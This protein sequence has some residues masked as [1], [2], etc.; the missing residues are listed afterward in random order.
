MRKKIVILGPLGQDG[1]M[2]SSLLNSDEFEVYGICKEGTDPK[3]IAFHSENFNTKI[4]CIDLSNNSNVVNIFNHIKPNVIVNFC[5]VTNVF[6][7]WAD[8]NLIFNQNCTIPINVMEYISKNNR[9]IFFF[10]SSSSLMYGRSVKQHVNHLTNFAPIHPYG[11]TKLYA[12]NFLNEYRNQFNLKCSSGVFFNHESQYRGEKFL[13]KKVS[14]F[15]SKILMGEKG[16]LHLG[17]L[18]GQR[19]ISH[20]LDFML[21][22]KHIIENDLNDDYI[23]SSGKLT[24]TKDLVNQFFYSY[25]LNMEEF[26]IYDDSLKRKEEPCVYGDSTKLASTGWKPKKTINDL[27]YDMVEFESKNQNFIY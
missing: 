13:T 15:I 20:A 11:I 21:G 5:G 27:I 25:G 12:H 26:V 16:K 22:I 6:D 14:K 4:F 23:F 3:R 7:P 24:T 9:D 19:D 17:D 1:K 10:Q 18:S 2:L 8:M